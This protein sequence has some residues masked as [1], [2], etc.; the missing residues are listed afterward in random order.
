MVGS[1]VLIFFTSL[2]NFIA[3]KQEKPCLRRKYDDLQKVLSKTL[4]LILAPIRQRMLQNTK[5]V[6]FPVIWLKFG[7]RVNLRG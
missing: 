1:L 7:V 4:E 5:F 3:I 2:Q 6:V